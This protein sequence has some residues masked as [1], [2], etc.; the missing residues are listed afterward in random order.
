[1]I[2]VRLPNATCTQCE[3]SIIPV[4][5]HPQDTTQW[6]AGNTSTTLMLHPGATQSIS[7]VEITDTSIQLL[8]GPEGGF[9]DNEVQLAI[10]T[11]IKPVSCGPRIL[12]TET[13]GF[14]ALAILQ[15]R[16]GDL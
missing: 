5:E 3:R 6:I 7:E 11:S 12:R 8:I 9:S 1:M 4:I 16:F 10:N 2:F 14:T 13:A 15:A